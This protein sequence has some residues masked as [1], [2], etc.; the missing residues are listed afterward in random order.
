MQLRGSSNK[1]MNL[2][3]SKVELVPI[4]VEG[5]PYQLCMS[6]IGEDYILTNIASSKEPYEHEM[7]IDMSM[8]LESVDLFLDIG[9]NIGNHTSKSSLGV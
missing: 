9:A 4:E 2:S 8:R 7:L 6:N 1:K 3:N 5:A